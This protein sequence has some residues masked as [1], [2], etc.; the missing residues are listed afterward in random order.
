M[1]TPTQTTLNNHL[2]KFKM[3]KFSQKHIK[4]FLTIAEKGKYKPTYSDQEPATKTLINNG[5]IEWR[6][7]WRGLKFTKKG[8]QLNLEELKQQLN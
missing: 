7:D 4:I 6:Y 3:K 5:Y 1:T 2:K 8:K